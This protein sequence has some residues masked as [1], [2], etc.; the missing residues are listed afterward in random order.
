[1]FDL[2]TICSF[3]SH[4]DTRESVNMPAAIHD[5]LHAVEPKS[6]PV[7]VA[8]RARPYISA[9]MM[10]TLLIAFGWTFDIPAEEVEHITSGK[11]YSV[12]QRD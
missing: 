8:T 2:L 11:F 12:S 6:N 1:M 7:V 3:H 10:N 9:E 4:C 5:L